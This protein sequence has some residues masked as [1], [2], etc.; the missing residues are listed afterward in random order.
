M[1]EV[2]AGSTRLSHTPERQ[3]AEA[4]AASNDA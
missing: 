3:Q 1:S 2:K 4:S